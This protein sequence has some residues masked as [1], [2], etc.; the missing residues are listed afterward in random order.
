MRFLEKQEKARVCLVSRFFDGYIMSIS[1]GGN[2]TKV[3]MAR[4]AVP[5]AFSGG[6]LRAQRHEL[7]A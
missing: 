1:A 6:T 4:Y 7:I 3:G 5:A 2:Q